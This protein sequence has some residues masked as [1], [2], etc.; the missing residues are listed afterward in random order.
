MRAPLRRLCF[1]AAIGVVAA[2]GFTGTAA[3]ASHQ[4]PDVPTSNVFHKDIAWAKNHGLVTGLA[5]GKFHPNDPVTRA[6]AALWFHRYA[7]MTVVRRKSFTFTNA[8]AIS[9]AVPCLAGEVPVSGGGNTNQ[10]DTMLTDV[11]VTATGATVRWETDNN[12]LKTGSA[13][14]WVVCQAGP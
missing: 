11:T 13:E 1:A 10:N 2:I 4:F 9:N 14:V 12:A 6:Q 3:L 5:D 8:S 7:K